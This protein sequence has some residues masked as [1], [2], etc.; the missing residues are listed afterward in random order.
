MTDC[1]IYCR[2]SSEDQARQVQSITDQKKLMMELAKSRGLNIKEIFI[3]EKSA[4]KPYQ[5]PAFQQ[6]MALVA[7]HKALVIVTW[8]IDRLSR[9]PVENGQVSWMLQESIITEIIT[10]DRTYL[11]SDNVLP[12][13][14]EGAMAN[15]YVRDLSVNVKR[16]QQ[17][18]VERG[19]YPASAPYGYVNVGKLKGQKSI[20]KDPSVSPNLQALWDLLKTGNYQLSELKRIMETKYPLYQ[21][22]NPSKLI[23]NSMFYR[24][25]KKKVYAGVF[26]WAGQEHLGTHE[27][28]LSLA[29]FEYIQDHLSGKDITREKTHQFDYKGLFHC[30]E[31]EAKLTAER[32]TKH[33]KA[34]QTSKQFEYYRCYHKKDRSCTQ[35]PI[36]QGLVEDQLHTEVA[37][38][39]LP[40]E[41]IEFG[42]NELKEKKLTIRE[43]EAHHIERLKEA[44]AIKTKDLEA[45]RS[46]LIRETDLEIKQITKDEYKALQ[47]EVQTLQDQ[48]QD[49]TVK[50]QNQQTDLWDQLSIIKDAQKIL[51]GDSRELKRKIIRGLGSNWQV[52]DKKLDFTPHFFCQALIKAKS[53][54]PPEIA[55]FEPN[56]DQSGISKK[57]SQAEIDS[58]WRRGWDSNPRYR[59]RYTSLAGKRFRPLS[60]LSDVDDGCIDF[61]F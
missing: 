6:M 36:S 38:L 16:G 37:K 35:K 27:P 54:L 59:C 3:D 34:T 4:A 46:N 43:S 17:S 12:L 33:I 31:C 28:Y 23:S 13:L 8:K 50:Q 51:Q 11:P 49:L 61:V 52:K 5:R 22:K 56:S 20:V 40:A 29:E 57:P 39:H 9:N 19:L 2:K 53:F 10:H 14:V 41:L 48:I 25:F 18:K 58:Y 32:K 15:Q 55:S 60:H 26:Q 42:L 7:E 30:G 24:I 45:V 1:F 47:V 44:L 21:K